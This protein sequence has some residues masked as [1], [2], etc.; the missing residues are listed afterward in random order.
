[1]TIRTLNESKGHPGMGQMS[2]QKERDERVYNFI[3]A[4]I[5]DNGYPPRRNDITDALGLT[6]R[7]LDCALVRLRSIGR[8]R[9]YSLLPTL[10]R[11]DPLPPAA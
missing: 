4:F 2:V 3:V 1:M 8:I 6:V 11:R 10:N 7:Q 5:G 9:A